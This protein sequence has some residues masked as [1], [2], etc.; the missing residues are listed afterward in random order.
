MVGLRRAIWET[1]PLKISFKN[2]LCKPPPADYVGRAKS[3]AVCSLTG[4]W[5]AKSYLE[6]D[7]IV[8]NAS[9]REWEDVLPFIQHLCASQ[10]NMQLVSKDAHKIKSYAEKHN[11][12]FEE[13]YVV[14]QV[15]KMIQEKKDKEFFIERDLEV[16]TNAVRRRISMIDIL[17]KEYN[18]N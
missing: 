1:Y 5:T 17:K 16:P 7:H 14:K 8:G 18:L 10:D 2:S 15:I 4:E 11:L 13:A 12:S 6:V 9:L 3:G